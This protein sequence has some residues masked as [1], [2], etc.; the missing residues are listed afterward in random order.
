MNKIS[1]LLIVSVVLILSACTSQTYYQLVETESKDLQKT[2][3][4][5]FFENDDLSISYDLWGEGGNGSFI[6]YN[7]T[8]SEL[9]ID[10]KLSHLIINGFAQTYFQN[11]YYEA[12]KVSLFTSSTDEEIQE[13]QSIK[14]AGVTP[15]NL[16]KQ[17]IGVVKFNEERIICIPPNSY[18][19]FYGF[20][21]QTELYR[22]CNLL[23][24]PKPKEIIS[25]QFSY[26]ESPLQYRNR[27]TYSFNE[28]MQAP[29][30]I[31]N[32]FRAIKI[33]NYPQTEFMTDEYYKFCEDSS[34]YRV[35]TYPYKSSSAYYYKYKLEPGSIKH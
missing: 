11:R 33:T 10:L 1:K 19:L 24:F 5:L 12:P 35:G 15:K 7:K 17:S 20:F 16:T 8:E 2:Q 21:L 6:I 31:E 26:E 25:S 32:E 27:I 4:Y 34:A 9:F 30:H 28:D 23:R 22:D 3:D 18:Q 14:F 13:L 29:K